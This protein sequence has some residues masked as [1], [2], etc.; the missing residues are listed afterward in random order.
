[1]GKE[2][3]R[4]YYFLFLIKARITKKTIKNCPIIT[5]PD[6]GKIISL[7]E[8]SAQVKHWWGTVLILLLSLEQASQSSNQT[9]SVIYS[10]KGFFITIVL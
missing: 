3:I 8:N 7:G 9:D 5:Q 1:M 10:L 2:Y 4:P 6:N